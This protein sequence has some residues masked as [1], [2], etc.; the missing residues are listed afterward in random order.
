MRVLCIFAHP[1]D[2]SFIVAGTAGWAAARGATLALLTATRGGAGSVGQPPIC[3]RAELRAVR[4]G[5]LRAAAAI[6]GITDLTLL[7]YPDREL[8]A[9]PVDEIRAS[10]VATIRRVRPDVVITF[11]PNGTNLHPDHIAI[12]RFTVDAVTAAADARWF[13]ASGAPHATAR[14]VWTPPAAP[15]Q[16]VAARSAPNDLPGSDFVLDVRPWAELKTRALRAHRT[17]NAQ[18]DR[19]FFGPDR[20]LSLGV[21]IFRQAWGPPLPHRPM[22]DLFVGLAG[23]P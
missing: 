23:H 13:P 3:T 2:E 4:E 20:T 12:S 17:Q 19:V 10:L 9:A 8:A 18:I 6:L 22:D 7:D 5:E 15:W 16:S 11:D 14:L 21:E 1:D